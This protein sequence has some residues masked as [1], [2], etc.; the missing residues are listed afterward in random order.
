MAWVTILWIDSSKGYPRFK[1]HIYH[2][3]I[4]QKLM[5]DYDEDDGATTCMVVPSRAVAKRLVKFLQVSFQH[6]NHRASFNELLA[7]IR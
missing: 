4:V 6:N 1:I 3:I 5:D 2:E 7:V